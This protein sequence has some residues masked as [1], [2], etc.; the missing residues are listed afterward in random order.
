MSFDNGFMFKTQN[1]NKNNDLGEANFLD[2]KAN[3]EIIQKLGHG[4]FG[5]VYNVNHLQTGKRCVLIIF[6]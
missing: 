5:A 2:V 1:L 6:S 3:F 4:S